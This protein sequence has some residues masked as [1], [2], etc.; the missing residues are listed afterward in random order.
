MAKEGSRIMVLQ[1][2]EGSEALVSVIQSL[3]EFV[4]QEYRRYVSE[5]DETVETQ[6]QAQPLVE[7]ADDIYQH[8]IQESASI[9]LTEIYR[10]HAPEKIADI[11]RRSPQEIL[12]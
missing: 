11:P 4:P 10:M 2:S 3:G 6:P 9:E 12:G 1:M 8:M 7:Q 5:E